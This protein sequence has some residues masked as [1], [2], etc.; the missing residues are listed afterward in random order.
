MEWMIE[1]SGQ[2]A[3]ICT[4]ADATQGPKA[5]SGSLA[6]VFPD[7]KFSCVLTRG[8][9]HRLGGVIDAD[10]QRVSDN[11]VHWAECESDGNVDE[12]VARYMD[13]GFFA[14]HLAGKTHYFTAPTG[15]QPSDFVQLE[16]EEL[17][18]VLDRRLVQWD[19]F[20]DN[21]EEFLDPLDYPRLEPEPI[22]EPYYL[23]RRITP[24]SRLL[25][26]SDDLSQGQYNLRRFFHDWQSSSSCEGGHLCRH[27]VLA[28]QG[29]MDSDNEYR[30]NA[31]P[32]STYSGKL[33]DLPGSGLLRGVD[34]ANALHDYDRRVGFPFAWFFMMLNRK[35]ANYALAQAV[36]R[37]QMGAYDY[38]A[39]RDLKVLRNWEERPYSV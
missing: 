38:L 29:Y 3:K 15:D 39:S 9:W 17:R 32:V 22:G 35:S 23:F 8:G 10:Y 27:W 6:R 2:L 25:E 18:E 20:P 14:T 16:I 12:L 11:I 31:K 37:D 5:L 1:Q 36:L 28:L 26:R 34:L 30:L 19:W 24:V 21:I 4:E 33:P 7:W 13:A